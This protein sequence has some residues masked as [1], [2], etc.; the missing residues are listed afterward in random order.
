MMVGQTITSRFSST[1][2]KASSKPVVRRAS[3]EASGLVGTSA[4][5]H[6]EGTASEDGGESPMAT[7]KDSLQTAILRPR[8]RT[9]SMSSVI[10]MI[11]EADELLSSTG[12]SIG[13]SSGHDTNISDTGGTSGHDPQKPNH[14]LAEIIRRRLSA[15]L[16]ALQTPTSVPTTR[17][18][19]VERSENGDLSVKPSSAHAGP[20]EEEVMSP[21]LQDTPDTMAGSEIWSSFHVDRSSTASTA[22]TWSC[23]ST[24]DARPISK[25]ST[26]ESAPTPA[27][28]PAA[29]EATSTEPREPVEPSPVR[30]IPTMRRKSSGLPVAQDRSRFKQRPSLPLT[31]ESGTSAPTQSIVEASSAIPTAKPPMRR[32]QSVASLRSNASASFGK[33][34]M[35]A[36]KDGSAGQIATKPARYSD[37]VQNTPSKSIR[38][39]GSVTPSKLPSLRNTASTASLRA[40]AS[41]EQASSGIPQRLGTPSAAGR[42]RLPSPSSARPSGLPL[43]ASRTASTLT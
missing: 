11:Q 42:S 7:S 28:D 6:D 40:R 1:P 27:S 26:P 33:P 5:L 29:A 32:Y 12:H 21:S 22:T 15:R 39:V 24:D 20:T 43:P 41:A 38:S 36:T 9:S 8:S 10:E 14:V 2:A 19:D 16:R 17:S 18:S 35:T 25:D 3:S 31:S 4:S 37:G 13:H 34:V 23:R 30:A